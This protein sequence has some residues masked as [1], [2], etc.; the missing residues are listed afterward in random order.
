VTALP[1]EP[2]RLT[3]R[4]TGQMTEPVRWQETVAYLRLHNVKL[5]IELGP[6]QVLQS[7]MNRM[8]DGIATLSIG[9]TGDIP[10]AKAALNRELAE[11][12]FIGKCLAIA[13]ATKNRSGDNEAYRTG[14]IEPYQ[15]VKQLAMQLDRTKQEPTREQMAGALS[16][17]RSVFETKQTPLG[18]QRNRLKQLLRLPSARALNLPE[19]EEI[20]WPSF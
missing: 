9:E 8:A 10:K 12:S 2:E 5:A 15:R 6:K 3:E 11:P 7:L 20:T 19:Q 18:E 1:H 16:M 17:L 4:L 13:A 14:V